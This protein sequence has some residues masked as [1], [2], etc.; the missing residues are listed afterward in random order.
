MPPVQIAAKRQCARLA[1]S[2]ASRAHGYI[3]ARQKAVEAAFFASSHGFPVVLKSVRAGLPGQRGVWI[4]ESAN[5]ALR[6]LAEHGDRELMAETFQAIVKE[7]VVLV[8]RRP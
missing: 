1:H 7:L 4:V 8:A 3:C 5:E 2:K 6:V